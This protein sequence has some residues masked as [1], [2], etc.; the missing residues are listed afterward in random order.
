MD[1]YTESRKLVVGSRR[2]WLLLF[3]LCRRSSDRTSTTFAAALT[4]F[5]AT[6]IF[7]NFA[8]GRADA[9]AAAVRGEHCKHQEQKS[10]TVCFHAACISFRFTNLSLCLVYRL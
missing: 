7:T 2:R 6:T 10:Y 5:A 3:F 1:E 8:G 9:F 4:M